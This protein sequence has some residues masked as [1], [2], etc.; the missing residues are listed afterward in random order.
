MPFVCIRCDFPLNKAAAKLLVLDIDNTIFDWVSYYVHCM[1]ALFNDLS[2]KTGI[3][4][5][6][7]ES[8]AKEVFTRQTSIE[9]PFLIQELPSV[10]KFYEYDANRIL[11][12]G[13]ESS[14]Q[15]F[16][17]EA[18][19][20]FLPYDGVERTL[21]EIKNKSDIQ[22]VALTDAPCYVAMWKLKKMGLLDLFEAIY[23]LSDPVIPV[24][25]GQPMV[26]QDILIKHL[27]RKQFD[28][29]GAVRVLP[30]EYEKPGTRGLRTILMDFGVDPSEVHW[31]GDNLRKDVLLGKLL[32]V[33]TGWAE[34]GATVDPE[35]KDRLLA[36]SPDINVHKNI[37]M[38]PADEATPKP[39]YTLQSFPDLLKHI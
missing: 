32:G 37:A 15:A 28:F 38:A 22:I 27:S 8:Q 14:R 16:N 26:A 35:I 12:E 23:G 34:Y 31:I 7:L 6:V 1:D 17:N 11:E 25:S 39:D 10:Q 19:K 30:E 24:Y 2:S 33:S 3:S 36:F 9:Y 5:A 20:H 21:V 18:R 29:A 13:V 4:R